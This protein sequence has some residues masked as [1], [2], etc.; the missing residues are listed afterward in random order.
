MTS[1]KGVP[2]VVWERQRKDK[3]GAEKIYSVPYLSLSRSLSDFWSY[4]A[5]TEKYVVSPFPD[6]HTQALNALFMKFVVLASDSLWDVMTH[7]EV[8]DF[9]WSYSKELNELKPDVVK[10]L[11]NEALKRWTEKQLVA[12][13][14][15]VVIVFFYSRFSIKMAI[16]Q[17]IYVLYG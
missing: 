17:E 4:C 14:I 3:T 2:W 1:Q 6:V 11:I 9:V 12:D 8:V 7:Q 16:L 5:R 13:N 15:S 10:A